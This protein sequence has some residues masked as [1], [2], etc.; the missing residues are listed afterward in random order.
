[1][2]KIVWLF[3]VL[4]IGFGAVSTS[5]ALTSKSVRAGGVKPTPTYTKPSGIQFMEA[6]WREVLKKAKAEKKIIFL[7]AY[8]SWCGPCKMLQKQVFTQKEVGNFYNSKFINVKMDMEK[9]EGPA[10][11]QVYPLEAY[12]TLLFIDG[13]GKVLKKF[14]GA[15]KAEELIALG[16]SVK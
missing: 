9:G 2:K 8:A 10:L 11:S 6:S 12:P 5:A 3:A 13:N 7:D 16:K 15:P 14:I 1:M 4:F